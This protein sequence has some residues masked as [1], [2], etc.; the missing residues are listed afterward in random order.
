MN[1]SAPNVWPAVDQLAPVI[2][3]V[4]LFPERSASVVPVPPS[5]LYEATRPVGGGGAA[6]DTVTATDAEVVVLFAP[7]RATAVSVCEPFVAV[8]VSHETE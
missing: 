2:V 3:P 8:V 6:F 7:S 4:L 5:K 1:E